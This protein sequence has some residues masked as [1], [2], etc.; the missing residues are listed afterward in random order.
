MN[1]VN[2]IISGRELRVVPQKKQIFISRFAFDTSAQDIDFYIK[3]QL[4]CRHYYS[5][6]FLLTNKD[7]NILAKSCY[8]QRILIQYKSTCK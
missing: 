3:S 2:N 1:I 4:K 8:S 7:N 5:E 6:M